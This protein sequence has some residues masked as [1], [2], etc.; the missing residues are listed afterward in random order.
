M[1]PNARALIGP[2]GSTIGYEVTVAPRPLLH[3]E[4]YTVMDN[5]LAWRMEGVQA[6]YK[7]P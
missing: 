7:P 5:G 2:K 6:V 1:R 3:L 4:V